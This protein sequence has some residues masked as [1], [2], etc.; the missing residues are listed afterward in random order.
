MP[1]PKPTLSILCTALSPLPQADW[2]DMAKVDVILLNDTQK[3]DDIL[4]TVQTSTSDWIVVAPDAATPEDLR[5][6]WQ[7]AKHESFADF[8][9]MA[10]G[11][12]IAHSSLVSRGLS[13]ALGAL[14]RTF[15]GDRVGS[16]QM[17]LMARQDFAN[18]PPYHGVLDFV[19]VLARYGGI[20]V[21]SVPVSFQEPPLSPCKAAK[22]FA[23]LWGTFW[24]KERWIFPPRQGTPPQ[25]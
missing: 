4:K 22:L 1:K 9:V 24:L 3:T 14:R 19:S 13:C 23:D 11:R 10:I 17:I 6:L 15:L 16:G 21:V 8:P 25:L 2:G 20:R 7:A 5:A 18:L 12:E